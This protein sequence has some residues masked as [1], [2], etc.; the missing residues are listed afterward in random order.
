MAILAECPICRNRQSIHKKLCKCGENLDRAKKSRRVRYWISYRVPGGKQRTEVVGKSI[1]DARAADG[2]RKVQKK[3]GRIFDMLPESKITVNELSDWYLE[4][5]AVKRLASH[6]RIGYALNNVCAEIGERTCNS[7]KPVDIENYQAARSGAGV[8]NVTIDYE[9]TIFKSVIHK[10]FDNDRIGGDVLKA[11]RGIKKIATRNER[12][13]DRVVTIDEYNRLL[14]VAAQHTRNMMILAFNTGMRPGEILGLKWSYI[15]RKAGFIRLPAEVT[16]EKAPKNIPINHHVYAVLDDLPRHID[17]DY[18]LTYRGKPMRRKKGPSDA[19][20]TACRRA[21]I[22]CGKKQDGIVPHDF[23]RTFKTNC[24]K[25]GVDKVYRDMITGHS[26]KGMDVH[27]IKPNEDDLKA[28]MEKFTAWLDEETST[29]VYQMF[30][31]KQ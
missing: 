12:A 18:V 27:Y 15:D 9:V 14:N 8:A 7:L 24:V 3:E 6:K 31:E 2:K 30:T 23:R 19:L 20:K 11:F 17:H 13:R 26:L 1:A 28:A 29:S 25:A 16:K 4:L 21:G 10:A 5:A 22:P